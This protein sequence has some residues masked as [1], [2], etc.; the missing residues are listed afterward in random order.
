MLCYVMLCMHLV[1][2]IVQQLWPENELTIFRWIYAAFV[3][4]HSEVICNQRYD[5]EHRRRILF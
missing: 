1:V 3:E 2:T 4:L 5:R